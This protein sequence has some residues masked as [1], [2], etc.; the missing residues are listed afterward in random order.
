MTGKPVQVLPQA[1]HD[2]RQATV[3]YRDQGGED[4]AVKWA[5]AVAAALRHVGAHPRTGASRHAVALSL[6]GLRVWPVQKFPYLIFYI[7]R[8][9][10]VDVWRVLHAQRDI[11]AWMRDASGHEPL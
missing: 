3:W 10:H 7:E 1:E 5:D 8:D 11:P 6:G 9:T 4:L 2:L